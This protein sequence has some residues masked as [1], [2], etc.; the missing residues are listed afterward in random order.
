MI[1]NR[2]LVSLVD[3]SKQIYSDTPIQNKVIESVIDGGE[4]KVLIIDGFKEIIV[5]F[6]GTDSLMD[7]KTNLGLRLVSRNNWGKIHSGFYDA[8]E[9]I[10]EKLF[11]KLDTLMK[12]S[13]KPLLITGHSSGGAMAVIFAYMAYKA[14]YNVDK[15][16]TFGQPRCGDQI[17]IDNVYFNIDY[18][19]IVN[20]CDMIVNTPPNLF[21]YGY[22]HAG[23]CTTFNQDGN[24]VHNQSDS[25]LFCA[26]FTNRLQGLVPN[27]ISHVV[28]Q[29]S[30]DYYYK[31]V[32]K[33]AS[34]IY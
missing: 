28:D 16:V 14:K 3:A 10:R 12:E 13:K 20:Q 18:T 24:V 11:E 33:L 17:F 6:Q 26:F 31:H 8:V 15:L 19:R 9:S 5:A 25:S 34:Y 22:A 4:A 27:F 1:D 30:I 29:H 23:K 21:F 2:I 32:K 7:W